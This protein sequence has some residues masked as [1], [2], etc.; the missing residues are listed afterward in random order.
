MP[1]RIC[2][3]TVLAL[4]M[5][6]C[7]GRSDGG[8]MAVKETAPG[9]SRVDMFVATTRKP[10]DLPGQVFS[11]ERDQKFNYAEIQVSI[12]PD[13]VRKIGE[14]QMSS[15]DVGDP[16]KDFVALSV[17][18]LGSE[19]ALEKFHARL[20]ATRRRQVLVFVHGFN[21]RFGEAVFRL[22]QIAHDSN[23]QAVPVLFTWPSR[24]KLLAYGYDRESANYSRDALERLLDFLQK[25]SSVDEID[26]LA[27]SMGNWVTMEALRQMAIRDRAIAPKIKTVML[28]AP[29]V[30]IDVFRRQ[31]IEIGPKR[32]A[33][34]L[35]ASRDDGALAA[36]ERVW[37]DVPRVGAVDP[38][39]EPYKTL[40]REARIN[41]IDLTGV[42]SDDRLG[43]STFAESP[44][45][46]R[47]IGLRIAQGQDFNDGKAGLGEKL[48]QVT[49]GA[50]S[51]VGT[52]AGLA[53][54]APLAIV[55]GRTRDSLGDQFEDMGSQ[56]RTTLGATT[57]LGAATLG[58]ATL[59]A[60]P[61]Y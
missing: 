23:L 39:A 57:T 18:R 25:D 41:V 7:A 32:P 26:V 45:V 28:A 24:G 2:L 38:Q 8:L 5:A 49:T 12:P 29:D 42:K 1:L 33:F 30:D 21:T 27:H 11:G 4:S 37:G 22:A 52:A 10:S 35:F 36:S 47:S 60:T 6:G 50:A 54:S 58:A 61:H 9:A 40:F 59:G 20:A 55:D 15:S 31:I 3:V 19:E 16:A 34:T 46:V 13:A 14:V 17:D 56:A 48:A 53:V 44:E 51:T 43:H